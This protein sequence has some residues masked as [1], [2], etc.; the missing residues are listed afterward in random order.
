MEKSF[1]REAKEALLFDVWDSFADTDLMKKLQKDYDLDEDFDGISD[2]VKLELAEEYLARLN[3]TYGKDLKEVFADNINEISEWAQRHGYDFNDLVTR[4][5]MT[6]DWIQ[7]SGYTP[8]MPNA[9]QRFLARVRFWLRQH[10]FYNANISDRD[11]VYML[12]EITRAGY[13][14]RWNEKEWAQRDVRYS[15]IGETGAAALDRYAAQNNLDNLLLAKKMLADGKD[16]LIIKQ[17]TGWE[18]G[19]DGK[20][21]MEIP[22]I[23]IKTQRALPDGTAYETESLAF[24]EGYLEDLVEAPELFSAYGQLRRIRVRSADLDKNVAATYVAK[25][26]TIFFSFDYLYEKP[27]DIQKFLLKGSLTHEIQHAIQHIEG[28]ASGGSSA[29]DNYRNLAGE[30]EARNAERRA[31]VLSDEEKRNSLLSA[32]EDVAEESKIYIFDGDGGDLSEPFSEAQKRAIL[33]KA[34]KNS[35]V[36]R[37]MLYGGIIEKNGNTVVF[38]G[39]N[40]HALLYH[41][42]EPGFK[43]QRGV[44]TFEEI[45]KFLPIV[46]AQEPKVEKKKNKKNKKRLYYVYK[47]SV[48]EVT[49]TLVTA[50]RGGFRSFYSNKKA[51]NAVTDTGVSSAT[52]MLPRRNIPQNAENANTD[53]NGLERTDTDGNGV[54]HSVRD[55]LDPETRAMIELFIPIIQEVDMDNVENDTL[56][57]KFNEKYAAKLGYSIDGGTAHMYAYWAEDIL[58]REHKERAAKAKKDRAYFWYGEMNPFFG[59]FT[60]HVGSGV[61]N[62]G[63]RFRGQDAT[64]TFISEKFKRYTVLRPQGP[65]EKINNYLRY[66]ERRQNALNGADGFNLDELAQAYC[67]RYGGDPIEVE[68]EMFEF[69]RH[70]KKTD[71]TKEYNQYHKEMNRQADLE[72]AEEYAR[73]EQEKIEDAVMDILQRGEPI[74]QEWIKENRKV[75]ENS[76]S[77]YV[78]TA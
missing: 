20:W 28:F 31:F 12:S 29:Q 68:D 16:A 76:C 15:V 6:A 38:D 2:D 47:Y 50:S 27:L 34:G 49:Y 22:D 13:E 17:A 60:E 57:E 39:K 23:E 19:G 33:A 73:L 46:L 41:L 59:F 62:P 61:I 64:G 10:G 58:R 25:N 48:G 30:V 5:Q 75:R 42:N 45:E 56:A 77:D 24:F 37:K 44:V 63:K 72:A 69:F 53:L 78:L 52:G 55:D 4:D 8:D 66:K 71:V 1:G 3:E 11:L 70:L 43:P 14:K 32:T 26:N 18:K 54:R 21:R 7:D 51:T 40:S 67:D 9:L 65:D 74:T 35:S 36:L